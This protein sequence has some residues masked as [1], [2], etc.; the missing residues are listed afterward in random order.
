MKFFFI[1]FFEI[2]NFFFSTI[3][4]LFIFLK[5]CFK[6]K[7][8]TIFLNPESGFGPSLLK[9]YLFKL[10]AKKNNLKDYIMIFGYD[11]RRHKSI[12]NIF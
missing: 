2:L 4:S 8:T 5:I 11:F 1:L 3:L 7:K 12:Q 10:Y 9:P 6:D